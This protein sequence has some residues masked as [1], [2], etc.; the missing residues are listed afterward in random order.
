M[1][2]NAMRGGC[3][4][5]SERPWRLAHV[6]FVRQRLEVRPTYTGSILTRVIEL[7][8]YWDMSIF[9]N[10]GDLVGSLLTESPVTIIVFPTN[11]VPA[12]GR[13]FDFPPKP[14]NYV[15]CH[16]SVSCIISSHYKESAMCAF[17]ALLFVL[18]AVFVAVA[19]AIQASSPNPYS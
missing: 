17:L 12:R 14:I 5:V 13:F 11:P 19:L 9:E 7:F 18:L 3:P 16:L 1:A 4:L 15:L 8:A 10:E 2:S 6:L